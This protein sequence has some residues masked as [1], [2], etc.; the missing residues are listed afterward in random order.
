MFHPTS[1]TR[2]VFCLLISIMSA[3]GLTADDGLQ[4]QGIEAG[5]G[6]SIVHSWRPARVTAKGLRMR[7]SDDD[8]FKGRWSLQIENTHDYER[9]VANNWCQPISDPPVGK[10]V[11]IAAAM[12]TEKATAA[13]VCLQCWSANGRMVGFAST[14]VL[15]GTRQWETVSS[16]PL[17]I[18]EG[19]HRIIVRAALTGTGSVWF[20]EIEIAV[21]ID[22]VET[23]EPSQLVSAR[24]DADQVRASDAADSTSELP[25]DSVRGICVI[26][27]Q[28]G[29]EVSPKKIIDFVTSCRLNLVVIDFAWITHHWPRTTDA[30]VDLAR[31]LQDSGV[32]V[33]LMYRP[34]VLNEDQADVHYLANQNSDNSRPSLDFRHE[35]SIRWGAD[36]GT[37]LLER[38]PTVNTVVIYNLL[39]PR[40]PAQQ[41][42]SH[43]RTKWNSVRDGVQIGHVGSGDAFADD[44]DIALPF[45][46]VNRFAGQPMRVASQT[47]A[48]SEF[49]R[50]HSDCR[51]VP[52]LKIDWAQATNNDSRDIAAAIDACEAFETGFVIWNYD[53]LLLRREFDWRLLLTALGCRP[54]EIDTLIAQRKPPRVRRPNV[55]AN[56][57]RIDQR[58]WLALASRENHGNAPVLIAETEQGSTK[59]KC[60]ADTNVISYLADKAW[61]SMRTIAISRN[62]TNRIFLSFPM[63]DLPKDL[64]RLTLRMQRAKSSLPPT[65]PLEI[66]AY[67]VKERWQE[68]DCN[69]SNQPAYALNPTANYIF[70][71]DDKQIELDVST[72]LA[73]AR[74]AG[75]TSLDM[76]LK[77]VAKQ[78][79]ELVRNAPRGFGGAPATPP[80]LDVPPEQTGYEPL[81][82]PHQPA[83]ASADEIARLVDSV[84]V[85]NDSP[86][87]QA[88]DR[89]VQAYLHGGLD[90]VLDNG[91]PIYAMKDGWVRSVRGSTVAVSDVE[92]DEPSF[93]WEYT[94]LG[95]IVVQPGDKVKRGDPLGRVEFKGLPHLHLTKVYSQGESWGN[96]SYICYPNGHFTYPDTEPPVIDKKIRFLANGSR[97]PFSRNDKGVAIVNGQVDIVVPMREQGEYARNRASK[98]GDRLAITRVEYDIRS[99]DES[100]DE[101]HASFDFEKL[102]YLKT[103]FHPEFNR[104][105]TTAVFRHWSRFQQNRPSGKQSLS[106]YAITNYPSGSSVRTLAPEWDANCW[107][108]SQLTT[109]GTRR[110]P[111]GE[112]RITIRAYDF[113]GHTGVHSVTV[114]VQN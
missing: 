95:S 38:F 25:T 35:D 49:E 81:P 15:K 112:Y 90:I 53:H 60:S 19:T 44:V 59:I 80:K 77:S 75:D 73:A 40:A 61:G 108:T 96:W 110:Y 3:A 103:P 79:R 37:K 67:R 104:G 21:L 82:W 2:P 30:A 51:V 50:N 57:T 106:Y 12:R 83:D 24:P 107:D 34:R 27:S 26:A 17:R 99:K 48:T 91:T 70:Q 32:K 18:P 14:P 109:E 36:W 42:L 22:D 47:K 87:Y 89:G 56:N 29:K 7:R 68:V 102:T 105:I 39:G 5:S 63:R 92:S 66:T 62:D 72:L 13:N 9:P 23:S 45:V 88:D 101:R 8:P 114:N 84:W 85:I 64:K 55:D 1:M 71:S 76:L 74:G 31:R 41:F 86:L 100:I 10:K 113:K 58:E 28:I 52:L 94:H 65:S 16:E 11:T 98:F 20:D 69:W 43:C 6:D 4:N 78:P 46:A 54:R 93:G 33:M 111:N 97:K